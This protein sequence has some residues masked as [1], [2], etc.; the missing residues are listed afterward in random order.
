[1]ADDNDADKIAAYN[2]VAVQLAALTK[3][4][5]TMVKLAK[6]SGELMERGDV[7]KVVDGILD[8][9]S[10]ELKSVPDYESIVDRI[11]TRIEEIE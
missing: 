5:E 2:F 6:E 9:V 4:T 3:M 7:E 1:M 11:V 10:E 8:I